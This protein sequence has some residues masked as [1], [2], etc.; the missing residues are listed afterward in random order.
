MDARTNFAFGTLTA[1]IA[2]GATS[3][4]VGAGEGARFPAVPFNAVIWNKTDYASP[5]HA[6]HAGAAE[7]VRV[8]AIATDTLTITRAQESTAAVN[9]NTGGKTYEIWAGPTV[10]YWDDSLFG[11]MRESMK[12][13]QL[14]WIRWGATVINSMGEQVSAVGTTTAASATASAPALVQYASAAS[15][16]SEFGISSN[17]VPMHYGRDLKMLALVALP[18][19]TDLR[20]FVGTG[21]NSAGSQLASDSGATH[22]AAFRFSTSAGDTNWMCCTRDGTTT[23]VVDSGVPVTTGIFIL[24]VHWDAATRTAKFRINDVLVATMSTNTPATTEGVRFYARGITL[25]AAA[26]SIQLGF[27]YNENDYA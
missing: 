2:S 15:L 16:G 23:Q 5:A 27:V 17:S 22:F 26:R 21:S 3:L 18:T 12:R 13:K 4:S 9:L 6:Y 25:S 7:I 11:A 1:G 14:S 20:V 10:R 19:L 8:T 24:A